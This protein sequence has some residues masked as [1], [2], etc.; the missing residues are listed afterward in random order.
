[1]EVYMDNSATTRPY[2]EVINEMV[3][4]MENYYGN[5]SSAYKLGLEAEKKCNE[6]RNIVAKTIS[7]SKDE[8]LFTSGGSE[9]NNFLLKGFVKK[10]NH[11]VTTKMEHPS[12]IN[13]CVELEKEGV[14]VTYLDVDEKGHID[15]NVLEKS[16]TKDTQVVSIMHVNNEFGVVQDLYSIGKL[17]K[18]KSSRAKFHVDA[19]QSYGKIN[20]DV[21]QFNIDL[22]SASGHKIHGPRGIGFAYVRRGL[23][24]KPLINGG[25]QE[26]NFRSGTENVAGICGMAKAADIMH[27][28]MEYN[29]NKVKDIKKYFIEKLSEIKD[30]R[31]NSA[32]DE[33]YI[34]HILNV[35]FRGVRAEVLLHLLEENGIYVSNGSA[36][37]AKKNKMSYV[38]K[39]IG[40]S[41]VDIEGAIRFSFNENNSFEEVDY[42]IEKIKKSLQMLRRFKK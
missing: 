39:S 22:L 3:N 15:L 9:S 32:N 13:T 40:L 28:N 36:C 42:T 2:N 27:N 23:C 41:P 19:V 1:M 20:I 18:E 10:G 17:I 30:I 11:I 29:Y 26:G 6:A 25:G 38:L 35:S 31:I 24:P 4:V 8:I 12:I 5:P 7:A 37:S 14:S 21:N 16:I 34:P 33:D